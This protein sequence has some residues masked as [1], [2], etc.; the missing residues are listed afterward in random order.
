MSIEEKRTTLLRSVNDILADINKNLQ[1]VVV[2]EDNRLQALMSE[3]KDAISATTGNST[4]DGKA[5]TALNRLIK[6]AHDTLATKIEF[7]IA[8]NAS[9]SELEG[10]T[11][12]IHRAKVV[13]PALSFNTRKSAEV[14]VNKFQKRLELL[15]ESR[16][17]VQGK[18]DE[19]RKKLE[20]EVNEAAYALH[21]ALQVASDAED[22]RLLKI[23]GKLER[24]LTSK[25]VSEKD[26]KQWVKA[27]EAKTRFAQQYK[28]EEVLGTKTINEMHRMK[29][30]VDIKDIEGTAPQITNVFVDGKVFVSFSFFNEFVKHIIREKMRED[31]VLKAVV[32]EDRTEDSAAVY[33]LDPDDYS[34]VL[35]SPKTETRYHIKMRVECNGKS[36]VWSKATG[37]ITLGFCRCLL[38]KENENNPETKRFYRLDETNPRIVVNMGACTCGAFGNAALQLNR[39]VK[40]GI[41]VLKSKKDC[42]L[43][44]VGVAYADVNYNVNY[45]CWNYGWFYDCHTSSLLVKQ[46]FMEEEP[47]GDKKVMGYGS[48]V[49]VVMDTAKGELFF[50]ADSD[51]APVAFTD[52]PLDKPLVPCVILGNP[53]DSV[54]LVYQDEQEREVGL[55]E[56]VSVPADLDASNWKC[57]SV[58][59][60]WADTGGYAS[61]FQ[62]ETNGVV[63]DI[64]RRVDTC[65]FLK[66]GLLSNTEYSFRV[67][68]VYGDR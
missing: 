26:L 60:S 35:R 38:W 27:G 21:K 6:K 65:I 42:E 55:G 51:H 23:I 28:I 48:V 2:S 43:L 41:K 15:D 58:E 19:I 40:W 16:R 59:L 9:A 1:E 62:V 56:I 22:E 18:Q 20:G 54:E 30:F 17:A 63:Q 32:R 53:G 68:A 44:F 64:L 57:D 46:P 10:Y 4:A 8:H 31:V 5:C 12:E 14:I 29:T 61:F 24:L 11:L 45:D 13:S 37:F 50:L 67:R 52:V 66:K 39:I 36:S 49:Q 34:F 3:V 33:T 25:R 47:Y 7:S